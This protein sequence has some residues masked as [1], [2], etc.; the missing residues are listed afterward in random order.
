MSVFVIDRLFR[1]L[2]P[3][4]EARA[5]ILLD[6]KKAFV[7]SVEPFTIQLR[8]A[9]DN[10]VGEFRVGI[11]DGAKEVGIS[12]AHKKNVVFA[13]NIQLRQDVHRKMLERSMHRRT[14]RSRNLRNRKARFLNRGQKGWVP[15]T[16]KQKKDSI[17]RVLDDLMKRINIVNCVVEQGQFDI[18]SMGAGYKL[19]SKEYQLSEYEGNNWRQKVLWRDHYT[20][21]R[22]GCNG[23][24]Y[25]QAHHI[26][27][28]SQG[29]TNIVS[30]GL[31][32]CADCHESL[33]REKWVL[34]LRKKKHFR[35]PAHTQQGKWY[36]FGELKNRF[37]EVKICFGW[38]TAKARV[39][40]NLEKDH[41]QDASAMIGANNYK[42][43]PYLIK[44]RRTKVWENNPS[45]ICI[46]KNGF[47]HYDVVKS[48]NRNKGVII[49]SIK[50]L[51]KVGIS[52]RTIFSNNFV[53]TYNNSK[54]LYRPNKLIYYKIQFIA[55]GNRGF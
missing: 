41:Y 49:G 16:I 27:P 50:S 42:C 1:P 43:N 7:Y 51:K 12:V 13:A 53:V 15:P 24:L 44:P 29:G 28:R 33:H 9:I 21:Q 17:L 52:L 6:K 20:C 36:L 32:L 3:T 8:R 37:K 55:V 5:R 2:L 47:R 38:M 48:Y 40:L 14:R 18:S 31:T 23:N 19:T 34:E 22:P 26:I 25:L 35:Y 10:P 4:T 54:L 30:N 46:E 11:D 39:E 45:K